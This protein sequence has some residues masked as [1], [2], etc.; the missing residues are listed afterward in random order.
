MKKILLVMLI[1]AIQATA[2]L[3]SVAVAGTHDGEDMN[4]HNKTGH[5][6]AAFLF[7]DDKVHLN[8]AGGTQFAHLKNGESAVAHAPHCKF[9]ILL[10]D[11]E[12][13]WHAEFHD[14]H[15]TDMT[16]TANTGHAKKK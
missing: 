5:E 7:I 2:M 8:Y 3:V 11:K 14:C 4:V 15:S 9:S 10:V 6:V 12:D 1:V 16:F 13:V